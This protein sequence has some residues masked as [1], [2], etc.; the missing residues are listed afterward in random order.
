M[1]MPQPQASPNPQ[2]VAS[3]ALQSFFNLSQRWGLSPA[4][5]RILLGDPPASTFFKWKA[6]KRAG[7]LGRDTL[8]RVSFLLGIHKA[9]NILLPSAQ[10][11]DQWVKKHND[12]PLFGG[13]TAL[14]HMLGGSVADLA[15]V[16]RFLDAE[17]GG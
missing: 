11:A 16:R 7:R 3:A 9:L 5:E 6:E 15:D 14:E 1:S 10:A 13:R 4:Q 2:R 12:A 8:D 17:R